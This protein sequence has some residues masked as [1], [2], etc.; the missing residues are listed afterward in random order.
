MNGVSRAN[1]FGV[2]RFGQWDRERKRSVLMRFV[3]ARRVRND[4]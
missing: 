3:R 2:V 4:G 1:M